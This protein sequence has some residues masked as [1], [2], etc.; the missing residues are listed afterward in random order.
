[1]WLLAAVFALFAG[2]R[3]AHAL[4]PHLAVSH[5]RDEPGARCDVVDR[6]HQAALVVVGDRPTACERACRIEGTDP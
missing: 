4:D 2:A 1:M 6:A 5:P 3:P